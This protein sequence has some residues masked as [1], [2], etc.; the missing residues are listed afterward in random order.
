MTVNLP[1]YAAIPVA[2][3]PLRSLLKGGL[4]VMAHCKAE[5]RVFVSRVEDTSLFQK[6]KE[7]GRVPRSEYSRFLRTRKRWE[8]EMSP[9]F[10]S[11]PQFAIGEVPEPPGVMLCRKGHW[12]SAHTIQDMG[13][14]FAPQSEN[15]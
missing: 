6:G 5:S 11:V 12:V 8:Y 13:I 2:L 7:G 10:K 15:I 4:I 9:E 3:P 14:I 1:R